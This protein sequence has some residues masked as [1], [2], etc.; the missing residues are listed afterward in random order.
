MRDAEESAIR[1]AER[2]AASLSRP[3]AYLEQAGAGYAVRLGKD[4]RLRPALRLDEAAFQQLV[5]GPGLKPRPGGG[6]SLVS[7][8]A[9]TSPPAGRPGVIEGERLVAEATGRVKK[10]ANLGESPLAWLARRK[11]GDGVPWLTT[12]ELAAGEKLRVDFYRSGLIGRLTMDWSGQ[13]RASGSRGRG[14]DPAERALSAKTR[15]RQALE[16]VGPEL[17][18]MLERICFLGSALEAAERDLGVP[19]RT[20]KVVLKLALQRLAAHYRLG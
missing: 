5:L 19:R 3:G 9:A 10:R 4:R 8:L 20:G 17:S 1:L 12:R 14:G 7:R 16:A 15:V 2:A 13:P 11:D 18:P 6:W